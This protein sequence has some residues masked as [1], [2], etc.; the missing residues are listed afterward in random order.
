MLPMAVAAAPSL[1]ASR[2]SGGRTTDRRGE[3]HAPYT[4]ISRPDLLRKVRAADL[5]KRGGR[6]HAPTVQPRPLRQSSTSANMHG[7]GRLC[8]L[9][10]CAHVTSLYVRALR[11]QARWP[12]HATYVR[13][14]SVSYVLVARAHRACEAGRLTR[15][16]PSVMHVIG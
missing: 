3:T 11:I 15:S 9:A 4:W 6:M 13:A 12:L 2:L 7:A 14:T 5:Q 1:P 8:C 10:A 16:R